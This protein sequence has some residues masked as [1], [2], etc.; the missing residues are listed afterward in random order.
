[1]IKIVTLLYSYIKKTCST[2]KRLYRIYENA[3]AFLVIPYRT[4]PYRTVQ[5]RIDK[6]WILTSQGLLFIVDFSRLNGMV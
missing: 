4:V 1:M 5:Y 6:T 3:N 2:S